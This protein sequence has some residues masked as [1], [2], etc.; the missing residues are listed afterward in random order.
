MRVSVY[1]CVFARWIKGVIRAISLSRRRRSYLFAIHGNEGELSG[2][3]CA[4]ADLYF[5]G[6]AS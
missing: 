1:T 3:I 4:V 5:Y 6:K 2:R